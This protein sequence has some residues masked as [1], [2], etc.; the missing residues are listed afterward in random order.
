MTSLDIKY[1]LMCYFRFKRQWICASECLNNDVMAITDKDVIEVEIKINKY[2]LWNGEA[3]KRKHNYYKIM[4]SW[5]Q[6]YHANRFSL[7]VPEDLYEEAKKWIEIT[8]KNYGIYLYKEN[9]GNAM[10]TAK[11]PK[12]L[13]DY[14][15]EDL[16][17]KIMMRVCSENIGLIKAIL[18]KG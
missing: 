1:A 15:S 13:H 3:K 18:D 8:N 4:P 16:R 2:D 12:T 6:D 11:A 17:K 7:C 14:K 10:L 9:I 5:F